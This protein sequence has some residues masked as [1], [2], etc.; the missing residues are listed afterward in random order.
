ME[1]NR[2]RICDHEIINP[3]HTKSKKKKKKGRKKSAAAAAALFV[4][5]PNYFLLTD[6]EEGIADC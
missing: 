5:L 4:H 1:V 3:F 6:G 2:C